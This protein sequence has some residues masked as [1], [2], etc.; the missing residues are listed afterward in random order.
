MA[1]EKFEGPFLVMP[2]EPSKQVIVLDSGKRFLFSCFNAENAAWV[3]KMLELGI[4]CSAGLEALSPEETE[5]VL[6]RF[7]D[8]SNQEGA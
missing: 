8:F 1:L 3:V 4:V 7:R 2:Q 6:A 5:R